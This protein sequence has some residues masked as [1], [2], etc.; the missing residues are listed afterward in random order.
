MNEQE[1]LVKLEEAY[2]A[3][4]IYCSERRCYG[5]V[6][7]DRVCGTNVSLETLIKVLKEKITK[8]A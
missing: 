7:N 8:E 5:C 6:F 2:N 3:F 4:N 1:F